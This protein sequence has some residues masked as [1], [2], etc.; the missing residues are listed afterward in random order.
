MELI[1]TPAAAKAFAKLPRKD[2]LALLS[3]LKQVAADPMADHPAA[4]RLVGSTEFRV[5]HGD[6]RAVY[7]LDRDAGQM[8][9]TKVAK[10][11]E[12]YR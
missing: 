12:V 8:V 1:V 9:V 5:R 3:K 4:K 11:S 7:V 10:R 2:A 6:W